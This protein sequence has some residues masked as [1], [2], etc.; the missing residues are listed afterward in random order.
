MS[1]SNLSRQVKR[2]MVRKA[3]KSLRT[4]GPT[5]TPDPYGNRHMRRRDAVVQPKLLAIGLKALFG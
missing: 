2:R 4:K 1:A 5:G 3:A